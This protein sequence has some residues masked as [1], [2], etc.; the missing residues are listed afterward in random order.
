MKR[1]VFV[2]VFSVMVLLAVISGVVEA[3]TTTVPVTTVPSTSTTEPQGALP[4][5]PT[6]E[7][8]GALPVPPTTIPALTPAVTSPPCSYNSLTSPECTSRPV[9]NGVPQGNG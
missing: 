4:V 6:T 1:K 8:Q 7:P 3:T 2:L 9:V 5:P